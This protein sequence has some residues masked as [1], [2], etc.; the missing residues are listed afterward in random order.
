MV[1]VFAKQDEILGYIL[2]CVERYGIRQHI[3]FSEEVVGTAYDEADDLWRITTRTTDGRVET[4]SANVLISAVGAL[5]RPSIPASGLA[6]FG[7]PVFH[8]AAW[9]RNVDLAGKRVAMIGTGASG[10]Q[11]APTIAPM[12]EKL[13]IFQ[14]SPH[15]AIRHPLYHAS[16]SPGVRWAM[17]HIPTYASWF[18]F[19]LFW[20]ASDG[21][22]ATLHMDPDWPHPECSLNAANETLRQELIAYVKA[23]LGDRTDLLEK[24]IPDYPPFGKRMLRDNHWYQMLRRDN[25]ELVTSGVDHIEPH[26]LRCGRAAIPGRCHRGWPPASKLRECCGRWIFAAVTASHSA[27]AGETKI[28]ALISASQFQASPTSS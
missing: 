16:V 21:F 2:K 26:A 23:E 12:V 9:D 14:R 20:A 3:R 1:V 5:N 10:M 27:T 25:V 6:D 15:W 24:V 11:V 17:R 4:I 22:H 28:H 13:T 19:Q 7:G 18:R 8:T